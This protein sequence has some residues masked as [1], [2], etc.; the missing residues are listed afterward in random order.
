MKY[1]TEIPHQQQRRESRER[2]RKFAIPA[3]SYICKYIEEGAK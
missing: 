1:L 2:M 3:V